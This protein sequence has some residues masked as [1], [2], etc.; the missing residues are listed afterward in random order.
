MRDSCARLCVPGSAKDVN[1]LV[2]PGFGAEQSRLSSGDPGELWFFSV[3]VCV[4]VRFI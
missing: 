4:C 2:T 1:S 3:C